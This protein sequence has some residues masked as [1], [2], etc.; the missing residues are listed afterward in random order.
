MLL[1]TRQIE[2]KEENVKIKLYQIAKKVKVKNIQVE[3]HFTPFK[4]N[5]IQI[6][7]LNNKKKKKTEI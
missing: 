6:D 4:L 5:I 7:K 3:R 1:E 2:K